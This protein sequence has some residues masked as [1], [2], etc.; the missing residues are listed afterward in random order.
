MSE[1]VIRC[2]PARPFLCLAGV[3][4]HDDIAVRVETLLALFAEL[5]AN[6]PHLG[7]Q[8]ALYHPQGRDP[9]GPNGEPWWVGRELTAP[10]DT[11]KGLQL[12]WTLGGDVAVLFHEGTYEHMLDTHFALH[13]AVTGLGRKLVGPNWERYGRSNDPAQLRTEVCYLLEGIGCRPE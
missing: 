12:N 9:F 5:S 1:R 13:K 8:I 7:T 3:I 2:D 10:L 11:P 4:E 6:V